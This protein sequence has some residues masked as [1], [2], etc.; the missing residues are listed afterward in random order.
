[1][2][3]F[4]QHNGQQTGPFTHQEIQAGVT[5]GLYQASDLIWYEGVAGWIPLS[6]LSVMAAAPQLPPGVAPQ[7]SG[8]AITSMVLGISSFMCGITGIPAVICG[9]IAR[10]NIKRSQ[11][12]QTGDGF[13][14]AGL[15]TGYLGTL[16]IGVAMIAGLT[17]PMVI[18]QRKKA[19]QTEAWN[20]ARQIGLVLLE[21]QNDYGRFPDAST[22]P[23]VANDTNTLEITGSSSN[24]RFRQ[25]FQASLTQSEPMFYAKSDGTRKPDGI[26]TGDQAIAPGECGF[27]YIENIRTDDD[28]PRPLAMAPFVKGRAKFDPMPFDNRAVILWTDHSVRSLPIDPITREVILDGQNLLDP[29]H[30]VWGGE[31]PSLLLPE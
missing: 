15:I 30:P 9:H 6:Q 12:Q 17:A 19:D 31:P 8:L 13:A 28:I 29:G 3:I 23:L 11:G 10:G 5:S 4:I 7:T 2:G 26:I 25:L 16:T 1:M 27:A 24:A 14:L 18:R 21:F 22:A 20:N